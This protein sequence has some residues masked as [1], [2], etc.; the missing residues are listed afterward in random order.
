LSWGEQCDNPDLAFAYLSSQG[1]SPLGTHM[2]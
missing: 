2:N 1:I